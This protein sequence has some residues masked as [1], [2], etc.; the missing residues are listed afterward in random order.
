MPMQMVDGDS[1]VVM[2][3]WARR[4]FGRDAWAA[5]A[6]GLRISALCNSMK[7]WWHLPLS[8]CGGSSCIDMGRQQRAMHLTSTTTPTC[9]TTAQLAH[10]R[11]SQ[12]VTHGG[13]AG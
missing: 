12:E 4:Q 2:S 11:C 9:T 3:E 10:M 13:E 8:F 7:I 1:K 5:R 6:P